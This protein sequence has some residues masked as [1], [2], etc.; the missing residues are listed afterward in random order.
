[1]EYTEVT[2]LEFGELDGLDD[3]RVAL[4]A[5]H[6]TFTTPNYLAAATLVTSIAEIAEACRAHGTLLHTDAVQVKLTDWTVQDHRRQRL[7]PQ[8]DS[9]RV[10]LLPTTLLHVSRV[11]VHRGIPDGELREQ[12]EDTVDQVGRQLVES[13]AAG[14]RGRHGGVVRHVCS[15]LTWELDGS[16]APRWRINKLADSGLCVIPEFFLRKKGALTML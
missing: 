10:D 13:L 6:T 15:N 2:P 8:S 7:F 4:D 11:L 9:Q 3:W 1:M 12:V 14:C 5:I 16:M